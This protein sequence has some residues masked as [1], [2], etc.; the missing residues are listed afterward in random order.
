MAFGGKPRGLAD[1]LG[2]DRS[3]VY[4]WLEGREIRS[5][6]IM[7]LFELGLSIDWLVDRRTVGTK[8]MFADNENGHRLNELY[9]GKDEAVQ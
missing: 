7:A 3:F 2:I 6:A 1:A 4:K 9:H 5:S 8:G